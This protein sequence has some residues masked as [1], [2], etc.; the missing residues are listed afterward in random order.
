MGVDLGSFPFP[1]AFKSTGHNYEALFTQNDQIAKRSFLIFN[2]DF[3]LK[4][5]A[6]VV[7]TR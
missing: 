7:N 1:I 4:S 2:K 3:V 5:L 6:T